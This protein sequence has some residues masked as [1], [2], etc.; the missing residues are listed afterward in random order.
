M[1]V[2]YLAQ[3]STTPGSLQKQL[4]IFLGRSISSR[5]SLAARGPDLPNY[6]LP[7]YPTRYLACS[8]GPADSDKMIVLY[9]EDG[10][11]APLV[12]NA[13]VEKGIEN[14]YECKMR[15]M[16]LAL[17]AYAVGN[18]RG[19]PDVVMILRYVL[20]GGFLGACAGCPAMLRGQPPSPELLATLMQARSCNGSA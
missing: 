4:T 17:R 12:A 6:P 9:D 8:K 15:K 1:S 19:T 14:T 2:T 11:T 16:S 7:L 10:K 5:P 13:F 20:N 18:A 3:S